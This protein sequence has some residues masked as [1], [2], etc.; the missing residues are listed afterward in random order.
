M[1][2]QGLLR[3]GTVLQDTYEVLRLIGEGGM[4]A[5]YEGVQLRLGKRVAIKVMARELA[6]NREA[7]SRF[8]REAEVASQIGHPHLVQ[9]F[10][11]GA[12]PGGDPYFVMEFL[13]GEDLE[14]RLQR[15]GRLDLPSAAAILKQVASALAATHGQGVIHRDLKPANVFL[16]S[17]EGM[18][19]FV[20]VLD[21][22]ISKAKAAARKLTHGSIVMGTPHYMAPEQARG[23]THEIDHRSDEWALACIAWEM[24][25]GAHAFDGEDIPSLLFQVV[26][27]EPPS[28][29]ALVP[30]LPAE[31][32]R[33][34]RKALSKK[35]AHRFATVRAFAEAFEKTVTGRPAGELPGP[36]ARKRANAPET[37]AYGAELAARPEATTSAD[38]A[39]APAAREGRRRLTTLSR[40]AAELVRPFGKLGKTSWLLA[41]GAS[42]AVVALTVVLA[43]AHRP[44]PRKPA[45]AVPPAP[46]RARPMVV[47]LAV[48][49]P[50]PSPA[51]TFMP[52]GP[53]FEPAG[54]DM[55]RAGV[56]PERGRAQGDAG[57]TPSAAREA[58]QHPAELV[59]P[60]GASGSEPRPERLPRDHLPNPL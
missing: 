1:S 29:A 45:L 44:A 10:D 48:S 28:L 60:F 40:S 42:A 30:G 34:L 20:K 53:P 38:R 50:V 33:V 57:A 8:R 5:V 16:V 27:E 23:R 4:G 51:A 43:L 14:A 26:H 13:E 54:A 35:P 2:N 46:T 55:A 17:A 39:A 59:D 25:S 3:P 12:A 47:P 22:G 24:V 19:D 56:R 21:F 6:A 32:E 11:F 58:R 52:M 36:V 18:G 49:L 9:V 7:L 15:V 31:L 37:L 41:G